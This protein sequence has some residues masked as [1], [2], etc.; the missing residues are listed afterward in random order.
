[1]RD[2]CRD[3]ECELADFNGEAN[4]VHLLLR[5][6]PK[7]AL[8]RLASSLKEMSSRRVAAAVP[9]PA[10]ALLADEPAVI[11]LALRR[12]TAGGAPITALR[13]Y[14]EQQDRPA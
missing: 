11:R 7:V 3:F 2:A 8:S 4:H 10:Q 13:Q 12:I 5:F 6:P 9:G 14:I 1:M